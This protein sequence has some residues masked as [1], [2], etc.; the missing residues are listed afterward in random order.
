MK[1]KLIYAIL[2]FTFGESIAQ[3]NENSDTISIN[4]AIK[5]IENVT[6]S[7]TMKPVKK[8]D[9][10]VPVEI[11]NQQFFKKNPTPNLFEAL[12][13]INGVRPQ[14]NC[15]VCNTGDI[16]INGLDGAYT[17][18]LIDGMPMVSSLG[19]VYGLSG[20]PTSL[21][22][23][24]EIIKGP[25]SSL[26]GSEA[27]AGLINI[28]TKNAESAPIFSADFNSSTWGEYNTDMAFKT[29]IGKKVNV[30]TGINYFN[31][32]N[33]I[34]KNH[35]N[36]TDV[37]LQD[38]ISI[39]QKWNFKRKNNRLMSLAGRYLYED[40]WG[41]EMNWTK[42][43]RGGE[44]IYAE[45]I[46][47]NRSEIFGSYELPTTEKLTSSFSFINHEQN[48]RYGSTSYIA[49]QKVAFGQL[50][51]DKTLGKHDLLAGLA[52]RYTYYDDNTPATQNQN[53]NQPQKDWLPG[54]F[55]QD[56]IKFSTKHHLLMGFRLDN[57]S[58]HG[59]IY[60][61]RIAY[62]WKMND[63]NILRIN[64]G[65]GFRVVNLFTE[66]HAALTGA[67]TVE[68]TETINPEKSFN[69]NINFT[70]K[71]YFSSGTNISIDATAFYTYFNNRIIPDY[72]TNPNK[73]IYNNLDGFAVSKGVS[74]NTDFSFSNGMQLILGATLMDNSTTENGIKTRQI[75]TEQF[76]GT[77][78]LSYP[79]KQLNLRIDYTGNVFSP[80]RLPLAGELD[81]RNPNSPWWSLQNIQLTYNKLKNIEIY[82]G[83]KN[84]LNWT[85]A[86]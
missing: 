79:I 45:S 35:D 47:T 57:H 42:K 18:V 38:R 52:L 60:T 56:E 48:S 13:N 61:P 72:E 74:L 65:T 24:I 14:L 51:W 77:W 2:L 44:E 64:A 78:S 6:I 1:T 27:V 10:P 43:Y 80:M 49:N 8:S 50:I 62:K 19:T 40:R 41:G 28:I 17:M 73:I 66:D 16:K 75:L 20:I 39:F 54:F 46:Y 84:L 32:Q 22:E 23:R 86:K 71:I 82:G 7:A 25:A 53:N 33:K 83:I 4:K 81:P 69:T 68:I 58:S 85:P 5:D 30:L 31:F 59:N 15:S 37:T 76:T 12:Q 29:N 70:K 21:I 55:I 63:E 36:F 34:D 3:T 11:Y 67:R 26:Y 9:S